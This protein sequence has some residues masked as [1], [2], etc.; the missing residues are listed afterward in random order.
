MNNDESI[1]PAEE[2]GV[3]QVSAR[4]HDFT[5]GYWDIFDGST[6]IAEFFN[7]RLLED[8]KILQ[9]ISLPDGS[10]G[11]GLMAYS[12][13][14]NIWH[15]FVKTDDGTATL[16]TGESADYG[17][18]IYTARKSLGDGNSRLRRWTL[19]LLSDGNIRELCICTDD[20][21]KT[22]STEYDLVWIS[23]S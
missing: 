20:I 18:L 22:W 9:H 2:L 23:K 13:A 12:P 4:S 21:G 1:A 17:N 5:L 14:L 15:Y 16:F 19:T 3:D 10:T 11:V 7:E 8:G 6:K